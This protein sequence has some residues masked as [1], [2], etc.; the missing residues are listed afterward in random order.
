VQRVEQSL[1]V[2]VVSGRRL[3]RRPEG[4]PDTPP[5]GPAAVAGLVRDDPQQ[6]GTEGL[7][8]PEAAERA[9]RLEERV[10]DGVLGVG[11][12]AG[13]DVGEPEGDLLVRCDQL[14]KGVLVAVQRS[15]T[16]QVV[17][18]IER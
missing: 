5:R 17:R 12:G 1:P 4:E 13:D 14:G 11:G 3:G 10:L 15:R 9:P 2:D 7:A 16:A 6:P 8:R 18:S